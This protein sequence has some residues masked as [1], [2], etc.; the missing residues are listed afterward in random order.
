MVIKIIGLES[1]LCIVLYK[2]LIKLQL[3]KPKLMFLDQRCCMTTD[4]IP[5][6][7]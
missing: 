3:K 6:G 4:M 5:V 7:V 2:R 1:I